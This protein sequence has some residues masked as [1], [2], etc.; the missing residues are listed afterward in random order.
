[1]D[2]DED[3]C[4]PSFNNFWGISFGCILKIGPERPAERLCGYLSPREVSARE[5]E[6]RYSSPP[7]W[8]RKRATQ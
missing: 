3:A 4:E 5:R 1:M 6:M 2:I 7:S 8:S